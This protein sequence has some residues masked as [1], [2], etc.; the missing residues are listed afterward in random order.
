MTV[1]TPDGFVFAPGP[2][3]DDLRQWS[4][5]DITAMH[6]LNN[7]NMM[8]TKVTCGGPTCQPVPHALMVAAWE[9]GLS[10]SAHALSRVIGW[11]P[12]CAVRRV[13]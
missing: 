10:R 5:R 3:S 4:L 7:A 6:F 11:C 13:P 9:N 1:H 12:H 2:M 8:H